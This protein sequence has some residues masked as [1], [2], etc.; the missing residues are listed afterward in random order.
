MSLSRKYG[1]NGKTYHV[2]WSEGTD[3]TDRKNWNYWNDIQNGVKELVF[4]EK[5][6]GEGSALNEFGVFARSHAAPSDK[7]WS[8]YLRQRH[9]IMVHDLKRDNIEIFG[10]N[11]FAVHSILYPKLED[12]FHVFAVRRM[13]KWLSWEEVEWWASIFDMKTVP[14]ISRRSVAGLTEGDLKQ[15]VQGCMVKPSVFGSY[16][17]I[18][19]RACTMEGVVFRNTSD[20]G[21]DAFVQNVYKTVRKGHVKTDERWEVNWK[22]AWLKHEMET[23]A[24]SNGLELTDDTSYLNVMDLLNE[25]N[26]RHK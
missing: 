23:Y 17:T 24:V 15:Y 8:A 22:R 7:P 18:D 16:D 10:E 11:M 26:K 2:P 6:D 25:K 13:D 4:T 5:M 3:S 9:A 21:V 12:H 20:Y 14:V 1:D 19:K